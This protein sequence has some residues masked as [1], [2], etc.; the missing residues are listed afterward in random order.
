MNEGRGKAM[1]LKDSKAKRDFYTI[2]N[3]ICLLYL[4]LMLLLFPL[5]SRDK[6]FD[7]LQAR[8]DFFWICSSV[9]SVLL[10]AFVA[11]YSLTLKKEERKE[12]LP[13]LFWKKEAGKKK[14]LFA[15][16][17]PFCLFSFSFPC[18]FPDIL[19]KPGGEV[20][21]DIWAF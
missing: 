11:L 13:S 9:F 21:E 1:E 3:G 6:Y 17:L 18:S 12:I 16:D 20:R 5:Y 15:T 4:A 8:F 10:F 2:G 14:P 19:T 7:I